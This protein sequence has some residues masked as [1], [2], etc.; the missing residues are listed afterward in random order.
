[1]TG[2]RANRCIWPVV[3]PTGRML[4]LSTGQRMLLLYLRG[5][6]K[7]GRHRFTLLQLSRV[8]GIDVS[9][10]SRG[11][12]R[13]A[14]FHMVGRRSTRGRTGQTITWKIRGARSALRPR[15]TVNVATS[16]PSVGYLTPERW[17][18]NAASGD[19]QT[20]RR[21]APPRLLWGRCAAGHRSRLTRWSWTRHP[22]ADR[23]EL[24]TFEGVWIGVCRRCGDHVRLPLQVTVRAVGT[25]WVRAGAV[26]ASLP[27]V[28][29][30]AAGHP[31]QAREQ[32]AGPGRLAQLNDDRSIG[33][34]ATPADPNDQHQEPG[35]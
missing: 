31:R 30:A 12:D 16:T 13:L 9:N 26:A 7:R 28:A 32:A 29:A 15:F 19:R 4:L 1:M 24:R 11:L 8:A 22:G 33:S 35:D 14:G 2:D 18:A 21:L 23:T 34:L 27:A 10:V 3:T 25:E 5:Q 17:Q 20:V 6:M